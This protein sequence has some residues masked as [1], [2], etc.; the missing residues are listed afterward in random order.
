[1]K[2]FEKN[3]DIRIEEDDLKDAKLSSADF[4]DDSIR[5]RAFINVLGARLAMKMLFSHKIEANNLYSLYTIH[6][7][8]EELDIADIYFQGIKIDVRLVFNRDEIFIPKSHFKYDLLPDLYLVLE[9]AK[10]FSAVEF[11]GFFEPK[12]LNKQNANKDFYFYECERLNDPKTIKTFLND[13]VI[14]DKFS[15]SQNGL[16]NAEELFLPL[17]DKEIS[18]KEKLA[19][20]KQLT[21]DIS[22]REKMVEFENFEI[23]SKEAAKNENLAVDK[24]LDIIGSQQLFEDENLNQSKA[25]IKAEVIGE[26]LT[27]LLDEELSKKTE[28]PT[29]KNI[30]DLASFEAE[31]DDEFLESITS[32]ETES[33]NE[34]TGKDNLGTLVAGAVLGG[35]VAGGV[36]AAAAAGMEAESN[37]IKDT[38]E[39]VSTGAELVSDFVQ[40]RINDNSFDIEID[41]E[42]AEE[43]IPSYI[44][45]ELSNSRE[46]EEL[47][48]EN[49]EYLNSFE[50]DLENE[51]IEYIVQ[52]EEEIE[53]KAEE[54]GEANSK[55]QIANS[56]ESSIPHT[57]SSTTETGSHAPFLSGSLC[58]P[59]DLST[60][61]PE[62]DNGCESSEFQE[63]EIFDELPELE[64]FENLKGSIE[65]KY[66]GSLENKE[67][68]SSDKE[69][70]DLKDFDFDV[71]KETE[72][73]LQAELD[74]DVVSF[75]T[76]IN[77][78]GEVE[79]EESIEIPET[80]E[81]IEQD[82]EPVGVVNEEVEEA[83]SNEQIAN[84]EEIPTSQPLAFSASQLE[85]EALQKFRELEEEEEEEKSLTIEA[86]DE[87]DKGDSDE[88]ISQVDE[89]L[90]DA[91]FSNEQ[92]ELL[93]ETLILDLEA[94]PIIS[95]PQTFETT[96]SPNTA[97][98]NFEYIEQEDE[99]AE[100]LPRE[101]I[102]EEFKAKDDEE[103]INLLFKEEKKDNISE[104]TFD[105]IK[106][107]LPSLKDKKMIIA[108]SVA[109]VVF[110]S[111]VI[112]SS[113][114]NNK[115][116]ETQFSQN[117]ANAPISAQE[118]PLNNFS[119]DS[120][121]NSDM[122]QQVSMQN[123]DLFTQQEIPAENRQAETN[124]DMGKAVSDAFLS[125]P[126]NATISKVA[127]EV[128]EDFAYN[129][130]F[131]K[132]LQIAGKNLKLNLQNNL[133][134]AT[135][136]AYSNRVVVDLAISKDG[137]LQSE[138]LITSSGSKQIDKIVL[139]SVKETLMYLKM[140]SSELGSNSVNAT[141]IINF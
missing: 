136:M 74:D 58:Q 28:E 68:V 118:Q 41:D 37:L 119:Q 59:F 94:D 6:N 130:G 71:L 14:E 98:P 116:G 27:D 107:M 26:V 140:P 62:K 12:T 114:I 63:D 73:I 4:S 45:S 103:E 134:L 47:T 83:N 128:P 104:L 110:A 99:M 57:S 13:F 54:M 123:Q 50:E 21:K 40:D 11:L 115:N 46:A 17:S 16:E 125:E 82:T 100:S 96:Y 122:T 51:N 49:I 36:M 90:K 126:V 22:L 78:N 117:M 23:L 39:I 15:I 55:E 66:F 127:W 108:A 102:A 77:N 87:E 124:R 109:S 97:P 137:A 30:I 18:K 31:L 7:V 61:K 60:V 35:A 9:L 84:S 93:E 1:M 85:D 34:A 75:D 33:K 56:E 48:D 10:D 24:V 133:L 67:E 52:S 43:T 135:E 38:A 53:D 120:I 44:T 95:S 25:E 129:D 19:L 65:E 80:P 3:S 64:N 2:I 86:E 32:S 106:K 113:I 79:Q 92:F 91:D 141:L 70:I 29:E 69:V 76:I 138:N 8:I 88:F 105:D 81:E 5:K 131:R 111:V 42:F 101:I 89:F 121:D 139:Q 72:T 112:G 20:F 132:Y